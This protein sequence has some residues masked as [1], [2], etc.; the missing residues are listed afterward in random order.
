VE[1]LHFVQDD[2]PLCIS[3]IVLKAYS[4]RLIKRLGRS[5]LVQTLTVRIL[6]FYI[7]LVQITST[8][9]TVGKEYPA[10][11][12]ASNQPFIVCF[13]HK[14]ILLM[15]TAWRPF[16]PHPLSMLNSRHRDGFLIARTTELHGIGSIKGSA[17]NPDKAKD[18][19]G[20]MALRQ[21]LRAIKDG[22]CVGITPDGPRGP[23]QKVQGGI[24]TLAMMAGVPILPV[25]VATSR[26]K[27]LRT[28]DSFCL[29]LPFSRG[30]IV[31]GAP[32]Y[33]AKGTEMTD[34]AAQ[35]EQAMA[36][37]EQEAAL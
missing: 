24:L 23:A 37:I 31:W 8:W 33:F 21:M 6:S 20:G 36:V 29:N 10:Q 19:G 16:R 12:R 22:Q 11:L 25:T 30:K 4:R 27:T 5:Q 1:I 34:A 18:K 3:S 32:L 14:R 7:R 9:D 17:Q 2:N 15:P 13:W 28:W 35:L 26:Y